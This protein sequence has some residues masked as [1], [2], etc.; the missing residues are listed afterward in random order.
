MNQFTRKRVFSIAE[1]IQ[2]EAQKDSLRDWALKNETAELPKYEKPKVE[3]GRTG[4]WNFT[5]ETLGELRP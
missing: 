5:R 4:W 2:Q 3:K 1:C